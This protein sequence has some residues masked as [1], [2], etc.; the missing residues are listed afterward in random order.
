MRIF[1]AL[2]FIL[3]FS[4][5]VF[6]QSDA[7]FNARGNQMM[8]LDE[9]ENIPEGILLT[10]EE[11]ADLAEKARLA[12]EAKN[13]KPKNDESGLPL[14][15]EA[16]E[17]QSHS[18]VVPYEEVLALYRAGRLAESLKGLKPLAESGHHGAE[19]LLGIM[20]R[21]GQGTQKDPESAL[22]YLQ[23]AAEQSRP[24][25]QHHLG[26]IYYQGEGVEADSARAMMWLNLAI[27]YYPEGVEKDQAKQDRDNVALRMTR[28]EKDNAYTLTRDWLAEKGEAHL[29]ESPAD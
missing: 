23:R 29:L 28:R 7:V 21:L 16:P 5:P 19:E 24:L 9:Y 25:A 17:E 2:V 15:E 6:A 11:R 26:I 4:S 18:L 3:F 10:G 22:L 8:S 20:Y 13:P 14:S 1:P 27:L 12:E